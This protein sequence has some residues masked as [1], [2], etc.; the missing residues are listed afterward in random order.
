MSMKS[1]IV[2][3]AATLALAAGVGAA[4]T[5]TAN[6]ATSACGNTC[7]NWFSAAYGTAA[8]PA[9]VLDVLNRVGQAA[10]RS[11]WPRPAGRTRGRTSRWRTRAWSVTS[12]PRA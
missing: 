8:H 3:A 1:K 11:R 12:S 9:F 6:A 4:G 5:L 10:S 2:T 7:V